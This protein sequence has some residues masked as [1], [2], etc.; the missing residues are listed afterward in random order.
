MN[1]HFFGLPIWLAYQFW[2][3]LRT[4]GRSMLIWSVSNYS[5]LC[6]GQLDEK[7]LDRLAIIWTVGL[8]AEGFE[9]NKAAG[10]SVDT[11]PPFRDNAYDLIYYCCFGEDTIG[12]HVG[13]LHTSSLYTRR[14]YL[15]KLEDACQNSFGLEIDQWFGAVHWPSLF[16][17]LFKISDS[18]IYLFLA[19]VAFLS[20]TIY[21]QN[22]WSVLSF[23]NFGW[24]IYLFYDN[25]CI[26]PTMY[27]Y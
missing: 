24:M 4:L 5:I 11:T 21:A 2:D 17:F 25:R 9:Y 12:D 3:I 27:K 10:Q 1:L 16:Y 15:G 19:T 7:E 18:V 20:K 14:L 22:N 23:K 13:S 26:P 6:T 8:A